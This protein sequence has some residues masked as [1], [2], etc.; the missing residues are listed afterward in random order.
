MNIS[1]DSQNLTINNSTKA[2]IK[3]YIKIA[4]TNTSLPIIIQGDFKNIPN[5]L[6]SLFI[7]AMLNSYRSISVYTNE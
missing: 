1:F 7:D 6:H 5:H 2:T 3:S 4:K